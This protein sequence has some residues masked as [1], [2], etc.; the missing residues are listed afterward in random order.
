VLLFIVFW[1]LFNKDFLLRQKLG[2]IVCLSCFVSLPYLH[3]SH[4]ESRRDQFLAPMGLGPTCHP[5]WHAIYLGLGYL[6]NAYGIEYSDTCAYNTF[7]SAD[8]P[9]C[10]DAYE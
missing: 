3:F 6:D 7:V 9:F 8:V 5:K 4:L 2:S 1:I 10:S